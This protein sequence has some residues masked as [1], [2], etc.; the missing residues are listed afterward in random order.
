MICQVII[1]PDGCVTVTLDTD[2][3]DCPTELVGLTVDDMLDQA[4]R[5]AVATWVEMH[6]D[7]E[8]TEDEAASDEAEA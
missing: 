5:A 3:D 2:H 8:A 1:D 7:K 4:G 6:C